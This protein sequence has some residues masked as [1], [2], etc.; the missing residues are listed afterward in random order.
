MCTEVSLNMRM[1]GNSLVYWRL[2][3]VIVVVVV[4][5]ILL[6]TSGKQSRHHLPAAIQNYNF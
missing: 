4:V 6:T 2:E 3:L 1:N 5:D